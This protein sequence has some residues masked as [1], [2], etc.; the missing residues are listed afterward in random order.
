VP[1]AKRLN[2]KQRDGIECDLKAIVKAE[3]SGHPVP[4][5]VRIIQY[6]KDEYDAQVPESTLSRWIDKLKEGGS[7]W[8]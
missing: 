1:H 5:V 2:A 6:L 4:T 7:L 8:G 3:L